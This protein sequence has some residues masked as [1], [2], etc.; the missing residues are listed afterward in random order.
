M[1]IVQSAGGVIVNAKKEIVVVKQKHSIITWSLPKG[2]VEEGEDFLTAAKREIHEETG[3]SNLSLIK[4]LPI[5]ERFKMNND[6][7]EDPNELKRIH[8]FLFTTD[9]TNLIPEDDDNPEARWVPV[10]EVA[11]LLSHP[12]DK[13]YFE[14]IITEI[15]ECL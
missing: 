6:H 14:S 1:N 2:H 12:K 11:A 7:T 4:E 13:I 9:E 8:F 5:L 15:T 10:T 3:L